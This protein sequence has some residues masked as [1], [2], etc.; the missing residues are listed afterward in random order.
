MVDGG[1]MCR[2][3]RF[4]LSAKITQNHQNRVPLRAAFVCAAWGG[5]APESA[6]SR[7][8][9]CSAFPSSRVIALTVRVQT[10]VSWRGE[11]LADVRAWQLV[12]GRI[13]SVG[14]AV[15]NRARWI[16]PVTAASLMTLVV[17][18]LAFAGLFV[19]AFEGW[20]GAAVALE[21]LR[22]GKWYRDDSTTVEA[23][24]GTRGWYHD[25]ELQHMVM[26][27]GTKSW[28]VDGKLHRNDGP[29]VVTADG[30]ELWCSE[31]R[32][33]VRRGIAFAMR[34]QTLDSDRIHS[35]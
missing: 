12:I 11:R 19:R 7:R 14:M 30:L 16:E 18:T 15:E 5:S 27:S 25:G 13:G 34:G 1:E 10:R 31:G 26:A 22:D 21:W 8:G 9:Q 3:W 32:C 23:A 28:W 33:V 20:P 24:S 6:T 35:D 17:V 29:A 4:W 2:N